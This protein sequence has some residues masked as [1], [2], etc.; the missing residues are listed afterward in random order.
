MLSGAELSAERIAAEVEELA[1]RLRAA[2]EEISGALPEVVYELRYAG[3]AFELP[4][5]GTSR[6]T[7]RS[8]PSASSGPTRSATA[9]ATPRARSCS[10]TSAWRW[11]CRG[12]AAQPAAA[13]AGRLEEIARKVRFDGRVARDPGAARRAAGRPRRRGAGRVRAA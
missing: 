13:P 9:T 6:P 7:R 5:P 11:S 10:S 1:A 4:V 8:W 12:R 3:Q 2:D